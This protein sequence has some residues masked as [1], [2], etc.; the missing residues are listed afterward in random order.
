L[1]N[2]IHRPS[3]NTLAFG[4]SSLERM[5]IT[6][7][8]DVLIN[9]ATALA[10][11]G[12]LQVNGAVNC[13]DPTAD[14]H[15]VTL[16]YLNTNLGALRTAGDTGIGALRYSGTTATSGQLYGGTTNP[17]S[18]TRL[19]YDGNFYVKNL[20]ALNGIVWG[21]E[22]VSSRNQI[23][24]LQNNGNSNWISSLD[25]YISIFTF[26]SITTTNAHATVLETKINGVLSITVLSVNNV[27]VSIV[28]NGVN[29]QNVSGSTITA[30]VNRLFLNSI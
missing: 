25:D 17:S 18:T 23:V 22:I 10:G 2:F 26:R 16:G 30:R 4:T 12:K 29:V 7:G 19:N 27:N 15:A 28:L 11:G 1:S 21:N 20:F 24:N 6:S 8:G 14:T 3:A 13:D 9:T 5:R